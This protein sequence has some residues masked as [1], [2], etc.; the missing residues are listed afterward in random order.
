MVFLINFD[1]KAKLH[2]RGGVLV[3]LKNKIRIDRALILLDV[4]GSRPTC[5]W[6]SKDAILIVKM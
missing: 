2:V 6:S 5:S 3:P 4:L 1:R